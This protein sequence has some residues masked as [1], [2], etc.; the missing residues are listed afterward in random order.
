MFEAEGRP[1]APQQHWLRALPLDIPTMRKIIS[2]NI[3]TERFAIT[4]QYVTPLLVTDLS[5]PSFSSL[6][7]PLTAPLP[8][9]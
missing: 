6:H 1:R 4:N 2:V 8:T 3:I 9:P 7:D 5:C